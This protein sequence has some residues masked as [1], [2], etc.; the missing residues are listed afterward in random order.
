MES[1]MN[2]AAIIV[3]SVIYILSL[4]GLILC[5]EDARARGTITQKDYN[6][7]LM[8]SSLPIINTLSLLVCLASVFT[9]WAC[10]GSWSE[11]T[12]A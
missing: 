7:S 12:E 4:I 8:V 1:I 11:K 9:H 2:Y 5:A 3:L 10:T 6:Q